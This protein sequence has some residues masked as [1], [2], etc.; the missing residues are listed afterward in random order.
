MPEIPAAELTAMQ[1]KIAQLESASAAARAEADAARSRELIKSGQ[2]EAVLRE[3]AARVA[4]AT[5]RAAKFAVSSELARALATQPIIPNAAPQLEALLSNELVADQAGDS[6]NVRTRDFRSVSD[7]VAAKLA[8]P[9]FVHFRSDRQAAA[10]SSPATPN[11]QP[12]A[13][14]R[15]AGEFFVAEAQA[16]LA[17]PA[18]ADPSRDLS[19]PFGLPGRGSTSPLSRGAIP[20]LGRLMIR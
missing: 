12:P 1:N 11:S 4:A 15:T 17:S 3:N 19:Q 2:G 18:Q 14:P 13:T 20:G 7:F 16:N 8:S 6:F 9:D 10:P 5:D